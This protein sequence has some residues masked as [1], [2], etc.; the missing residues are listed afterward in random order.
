MIIL[1]VLVSVAAYWLFCILWFSLV[2]KPIFGIYD[3]V[4]A[5]QSIR[6]KD[7]VNI[8]R[9]GNVSDRII[10][11]YLT[12]IPLIIVTIACMICGWG[13]DIAITIYNAII[14]LVIGLLSVSDA[15]L[16]RFWKFKIDAS[17]F[18]Y[19]KSLKGAFASVST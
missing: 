18:V 10:A 3:R 16:Y 11:S 7:V 14:A 19:L 5:Q 4:C 15:A 6:L 2:Q 12:A 13:Y 8:Y 9:H 17:V 1:S